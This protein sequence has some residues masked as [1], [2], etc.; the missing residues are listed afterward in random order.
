MLPSPKGL[1]LIALSLC[2]FVQSAC[3]SSNLPT[4]DAQPS[5]SPSIPTESDY[6]YINEPEYSPDGRWLLWK[7]SVQYGNG[8]LPVT[9]GWLVF[10]TQSQK[11]TSLWKASASQ[12]Y[13]VRW[14]D[15]GSL[16]ALAFS[17]SSYPEMTAQLQR[18]DK[19][20]S[21][22]QTLWNGKI[23]S[24]S[25]DFKTEKGQIAW[26]GNNR[27]L[28]LMPIAGGNPK[29][30]TLPETKTELYQ[31]ITVI[32]LNSDSVLLS[33]K[34]PKEQVGQSV[35]KSQFQTLSSPPPP[36]V[37]D[38]ARFDLASGQLTL[39]AENLEYPSEASADGRF[40]M[41]VSE[42]HHRLINT[43]DGK[44]VYEFPEL[45]YSLS[46]SSAWLDSDRLLYWETEHHQAQIYTVSSA[47]VGPVLQLPDMKE[48]HSIRLQGSQLLFEGV[49]QSPRQA[50][51]RSV[52]VTAA[53]QLGPVKTLLE[54]SLDDKF[55]LMSNKR[56]PLLA[57][58]QL[59]VIEVLSG[60]TLF[61]YS[62]DKP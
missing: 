15:D 18:F 20:N 22:V 48:L 44:V 3:A 41:T 50:W 17:Y 54:S 38:L 39:L 37:Y 8:M 11:Q 19:P 53:G 57:N 28:N 31:G 61:D 51:M 40:V 13:K 4:H 60:K 14:A 58:H 2:L 10:D 16:I 43:R 24:N 45:T 42:T 25:P 6:Q 34:K 36:S 59:K 5:L 27:Q 52:E 7:H 9:A 12:D 1:R 56:G 62:P 47:S 33:Y 29:S 26:I 21:S 35:F 49:T 55:Y 32:G 23:D 30:F 46:G